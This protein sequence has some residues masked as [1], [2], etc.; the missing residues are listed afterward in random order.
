MSGVARLSALQ[1]G[2]CTYQQLWTLALRAA[3]RAPMSSPGVQS[4]RCSAF[5]TKR[6]EPP[7]GHCCHEGSVDESLQLV[8]RCGLLRHRADGICALLDEH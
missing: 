4:Y 7:L 3:S 2:L 5:P 1:L 6:V 8:R